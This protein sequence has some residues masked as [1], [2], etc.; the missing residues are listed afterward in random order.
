M[1]SDKEVCFP[2]QEV[3]IGC[4][5]LTSCAVDPTIATLPMVDFAFEAGRAARRRSTW[6]NSRTRRVEVHGGVR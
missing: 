1:P 2:V 5:Q 4:W 3:I 6:S